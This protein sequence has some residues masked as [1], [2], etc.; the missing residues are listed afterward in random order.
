MMP[1]Y[2]GE[3]CVRATGDKW[4]PQWVFEGCDKNMGKLADV[5]GVGMIQRRLQDLQDPQQFDVLHMAPSGRDAPAWDMQHIKGM[6]AC[7]GSAATGSTG[8]RRPPPTVG[9]VRK[10]KTH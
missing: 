7:M 9:D 2:G 6:A 4:A 10:K 3:Q 1:W 5:C 8:R